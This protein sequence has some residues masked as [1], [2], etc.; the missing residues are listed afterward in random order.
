[1][2]RVKNPVPDI[3]YGIE[4]DAFSP[5]DKQI[6]DALGCELSSE[7]YHVFF[8]VEAKSMNNPLGEAENQCCRG[9]AAMTYNKRKFDAAVVAPNDPSSQLTSSTSEIITSS[10]STLVAYPKADMN[11]FTFSLAIDPDHAKLFVHWVEE[12]LA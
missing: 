11:S 2:P 3:A 1:M 8:L 7:L 10:A 9:G 5:R 12:K 6:L 4:E